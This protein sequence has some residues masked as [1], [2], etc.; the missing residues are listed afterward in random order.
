LLRLEMRDFT[1]FGPLQY[2]SGALE[3][4]SHAGATHEVAE[5]VPYEDRADL[6][7]AWQLAGSTE[8]PRDHGL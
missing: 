5:A 7:Q 8:H 3:Q 4:R 1:S 2:S 6:T